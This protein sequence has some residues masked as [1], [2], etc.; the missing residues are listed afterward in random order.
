VRCPGYLESV[1]KSY[2]RIAD[3]GLDAGTYISKVDVWKSL[4]KLWK[5]K[6]I[7]RRTLADSEYRADDLFGLLAYLP[8]TT[9]TKNQIRLLSSA[10]K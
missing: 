6:S 9:H 7:N 2:I 1:G 10:K 8:H 3:K 4:M 5:G